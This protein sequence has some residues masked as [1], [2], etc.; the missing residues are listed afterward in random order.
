M[1]ERAGRNGGEGGAQ[2][3]EGWPLNRASDAAR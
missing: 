2:A 1:Y 3:I